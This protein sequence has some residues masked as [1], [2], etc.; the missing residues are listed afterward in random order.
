MSGTT[1]EPLPKNATEA[2]G[3]LIK[4]FHEKCGDESLPA[5]DN[6]LG[7]Q[8]RA[9]GLKVKSKLPDCRLSTVAAAFTK[10]FDP[11][12]INIVAV[13]DEKFH[14]QG[15]TCPFGLE[16]TSRQLCEAVMAI[17]REYFSAATDGRTTLTI[18]KTRAAGDSIC[19]TVYTTRSDK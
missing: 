6:I 11:A 2:Q 4:A 19:D 8:G 16:N 7:R 9:L 10:N 18:L 15:T 13:S 14:I 3:L 1:I 12:T 17:D 5:I